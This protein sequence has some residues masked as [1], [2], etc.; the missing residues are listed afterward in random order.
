MLRGECLDERAMC[1]ASL[2]ELID[3]HEGEARSHR[4]PHVGSLAKQALQHENEVAGV[5][6]PAIP[7]DTI[8][9]RVQL[10]ELAVASGRLTLGGV[11]SLPLP[12]LG[13]LAKSTRDRKS[14]RLN[15]SHTVISYAVFCLKKKKETNNVKKI[16]QNNTKKY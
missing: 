3:H 8:V 1:R 10:R 13:P 15:S 14:T 11:R 5:E 16:Q 4:A 9:A 7:E 6:A 12:L 2:L